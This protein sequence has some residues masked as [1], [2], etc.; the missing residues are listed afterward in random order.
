MGIAGSAVGT[1]TESAAE[2]LLQAAGFLLETFRVG[3][4]PLRPREHPLPLGR[5]SLEP[6]ATLHQQQAEL[7]L[8]LPDAGGQGGLGHPAGGGGPGEVA[9]AG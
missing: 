7:F 2:V 9:L 3:G 8:E 4:D 5:Q 1:E 6:L